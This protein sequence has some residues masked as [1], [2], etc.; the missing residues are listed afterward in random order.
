M[1]DLLENHLQQEQVA[2]RR[3]VCAET[4]EKRDVPS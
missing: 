4:Q 2:E 1:V 3:V